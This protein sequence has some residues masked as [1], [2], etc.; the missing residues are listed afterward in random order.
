MPN[1]AYSRE[2]IEAF[3]ADPSLVENLHTQLSELFDMFSGAVVD[4]DSAGMKY[5]E[6]GCR[7]NLEDNVTDP[8]LREK[9]RPDY[10]AAC[11]RLIV[12]A[13]FYEAIQKPNAEVVTEPIRAVEAKGV[14]TADGRLHELD[15]L[16]LATGFKVDAFVRPISV[17][18]RDGVELDTV[19]A[20]RPEA[21]LAIS[22]PEF[23]NFF[24]LN[25]PNGPVGNFSLIGVA[26]LQLGY[27][28]QLVERVRSGDCREIGA[29][30]PALEEFEAT[31]IEAAK[32]TVWATGCR[33]WY[34]DDRGIPAA[35][36]WPYERFRA[37]M[38]APRWEA[39]ELR[40]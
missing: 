22:V 18:G 33:S 6:E 20:D 21:Y 27:V 11:K 35:W 8:V 3:R 17:T 5:I 23:A 26:E 24:M 12:S 10:R 32:K 16:V 19:W 14:R 9:L 15:V 34:L 38:A 4:A 40:D 25:G 37:E 29:T 2:E 30:K 7:A 1:P 36:P 28:L 31:R 39:Y 13:D